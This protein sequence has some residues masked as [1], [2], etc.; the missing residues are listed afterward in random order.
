MGSPLRISR[1]LTSFA[2]WRYS[3]QWSNRDGAVVRNI[4]KKSHK[5]P[6]KQLQIKKVQKS[7]PPWNSILPTGKGFQGNF[8]KIN[9]W[10]SQFYEKSSS[11]LQT[12][13]FC[14]FCL[15]GCISLFQVHWNKNL[16][17]LFLLQFFMRNIFCFINFSDFFSKNGRKKHFFK[18]FS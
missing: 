16:I 13:L 3:N 9:S 5:Y 1:V 11:K 10:N 18:S 14:S 2:Q 12:G 7:D 8:H 15:W 17:P 6:L 4:F